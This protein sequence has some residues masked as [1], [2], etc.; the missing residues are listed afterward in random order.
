[1]EFVDVFFVLEILI[2]IDGFVN[3]KKVEYFNFES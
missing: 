1:M 3:D 2:V